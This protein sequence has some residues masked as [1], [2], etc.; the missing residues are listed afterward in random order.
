[1]IQRPHSELAPGELCPPLLVTPLP[2]PSDNLP[3]LTDIQPAGL[4]CKGAKLSPARRVLG[5]AHLLHS[6]P[7]LTLSPGGN[8]RLFKLRHPFVPA[9]QQFISSSDNNNNK[10][11]GVWADHRW[12]AKWLDNTTRVCT[13]IPDIG[14]HPPGMALPR[15]RGSG[16]TTSGLQKL[17]MA[18]S[19]AQVRPSNGYELAQEM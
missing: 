13:S 15:K 1:V 5:P 7:A 9:T 19:A 17:D 11:A 10:S 12:N 18:T 16:L 6:A 3:T 4:R 14:T 8:A 2:A